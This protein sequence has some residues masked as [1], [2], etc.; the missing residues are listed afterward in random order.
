VS[1]PRRILLT[2]DDG[3]DAPGLSALRDALGRLG[4][5]I[6]VA[7]SRELSGCAHSITL[8]VPVFVEEQVDDHTY[9]LSGSPADCVKIAV[10]ALLGERPDLVVSGI[11]LGANVGVNVLYSGTVAG[12]L[13][14][15]IFNIPSVAV[16]L[17]WSPE[18]DFAAAG[19]VATR[20]IEQALAD[21][22][23]AGVVLNV[24][25]P[26]RSADEV[27][28]VKVAPQCPIELGEAYRN[29]TE[30]DGRPAYTLIYGEQKPDIPP[31]CD[32]ALLVA[33]Y[34]TVTPLRPDLTNEDWLERL[35]S[36]EWH[37]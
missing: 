34:V 4:E 7:P 22:L 13:E 14:G 10:L 11:N 1:G 12:A 30:A 5:V 32:W 17:Q 26:A 35:G 31:G 2:N 19:D 3:I 24:N 37:L 16:S 20:I 28:G 15:A 18:P 6:V 8:N 33:G 9:V 25:V 23:P 27:E 21:G 36:T 29:H